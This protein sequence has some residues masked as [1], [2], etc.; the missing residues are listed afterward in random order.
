MRT[1]KLVLLLLLEAAKLRSRLFSSSV[2]ES[3]VAD[4]WWYLAPSSSPSLSLWLNVLYE[5]GEEDAIARQRATR[6]KTSTLD[7]Q[8]LWSSTALLSS[9]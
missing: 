6:R 3:A 9:R 7:P 5:D 4:T 2:E 1:S 8:A